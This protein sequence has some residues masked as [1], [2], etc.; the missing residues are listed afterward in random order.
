MIPFQMGC[1]ELRDTRQDSMIPPPDDQLSL[2]SASYK[3]QRVP[4]ETESQVLLRKW[5]PLVLHRVHLFPTLLH[6][7]AS[8]DEKGGY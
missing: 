3:R 7:L 2:E 5:E 4:L 6:D 8:R 1:L